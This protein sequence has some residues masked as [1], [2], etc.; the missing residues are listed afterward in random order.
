MNC[1]YHNGNKIINFEKKHIIALIIEVLILLVC[2]LFCFAPKNTYSYG[3]EAFEIVSGSMEDSCVKID[4][5]YEFSGNF[6]KCNN[7]PLGIGSYSIRLKYDTDTDDKFLCNVSDETVS[8]GNLWANYAILY[9]GMPSTDLKIW[10]WEYTDTLTI[11]VS[12]SNSGSIEVYGVDIYETNDFQRMIFSI[13]LFSFLFFD[14][15]YVTYK[16]TEKNITNRIIIA[17]LFITA[18]ISSVPLMTNYLIAGDDLGYHLLRIEGIKDGLLSGQFP[19]RLYPEWLLGHGY[20]DS[21]MYGNAL[22]YLPAILELLGFPLMMSYKA[23]VFFINCLTVAVAYYSFGKIASDNKIGIITAVI[24]S[25][26]PYRL[27]CVYHRASVGEYTAMAFTPLILLGLFLIY[28]EVKDQSDKRKGVFPLVIGLT[29]I[30]NTHILTCEMVGGL[31]LLFCIVEFRRTFKKDIFIQMLKS[32]G[33]TI[34]LNLSFLVPFIEC[35]FNGNLKI[36]D[37]IVNIQGGGIYLANLF[38][39]LI[40]DGTPGDSRYY[41]S[42]GMNNYL[43]TTPGL[44]LIF[45][46]IVFAMI[47]WIRKKEEKNNLYRYG[48][49]ASAFSFLTIL[50]SMQIFPWDSIQKI[51]PLFTKLVSSLQLPMRFIAISI[52]IL[53][54][55][56][57]FTAKICKEKNHKVYSALIISLLSIALVSGLYQQISILDKTNFYRL[58]DIDGMGTRNA[59]GQEYLPIGTDLSLLHYGTYTA[60]NVEI[61]NIVKNHSTVNFSASSLYGGYVEVPLIK[62]IGYKAKDSNG[63]K[64][65][66]E[67]GNNNVLRII[68]PENYNGEITVYYSGRWYWRVAEIITLLTFVLMAMYHKK[69]EKNKKHLL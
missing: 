64:L 1:A 50:M 48:S 67:Y 33:L 42:L 13:V 30:I 32:L 8:T 23:F 14:V 59:M 11:S 44:A 20:D 10:L 39:F 60:E 5:S 29:G 17:A 55:S 68:I 61:D 53:S 66:T 51:S 54:L 16:K 62:Y 4:D 49:I 41:S 56:F 18:F 35:F 40:A 47:L 43:P 12:T 69:S 2:L 3:A 19:V 22:L 34:A 27:Y 65:A 46:L 36:G 38:A 52:P 26:A 28:T 21:I 37:T 45:S 31:L 6:A 24:Y 57:V 9:S 25:L 63:N 15:L 7:I 58:Y